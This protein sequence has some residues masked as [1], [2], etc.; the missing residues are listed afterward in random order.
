MT[1]KN[2][3]YPLW[4]AILLYI[5]VLNII[6]QKLFPELGYNLYLLGISQIVYTYDNFVHIYRYTSTDWQTW[7]ADMFQNVSMFVTSGIT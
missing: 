1:I 7:A 2:V 5:D 6:D 3:L 4:C